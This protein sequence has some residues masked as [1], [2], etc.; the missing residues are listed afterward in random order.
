MLCYV[1]WH[2]WSLLP[3]RLWL[4]VLTLSVGVI[5][6]FMLFVRRGFLDHLPLDMASWVYAIG[7]TSI[8]VYLYLA[9]AFLLLDLGVLVH[10]VPASWMRTNGVTVVSLLVVMVTVFSYGYV[11]YHDKYRQSLSL[12]SHGKVRKAVRVVMVS[13][14]HLGY[15]NRRVDLKEWIDRINAEHPDLILLAGDLIDGSLRPLW[16]ED[17]ARE[18]RRLSAPVYACLGNHEYFCGLRAAQRFYHDAGICLLRDSV[19]TVGDICLIGRDDRTNR[20]R[21]SLRQLARMADRSKYTIVMD[22]QPYHLEEAEQCA[23]DFQLSGHTH[24]GQVWPVS[25]ITAAIYEDAFGPLTK[26]HTQ[27]YVSSGLGIWGGKYR[28]G[29]RSEYVVATVR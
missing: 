20:S 27:Y 21:R 13:D 12:D 3:D 6:L 8:L 22:H 11:H 2:V 17:D 18:L 24:Y 23:I 19:V 29:T 1:L 16:E 15:H 4:R 28:I 14:V 10:L 26:G 7:T 9:I 25:W 5:S